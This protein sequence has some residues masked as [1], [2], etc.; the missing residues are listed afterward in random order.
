[1]RLVYQLM[2]YGGMGGAII[3][4]II[5]LIIF[6]RLKIWSIMKDLIGYRPR[7]KRN[8]P[9]TLKDTD[10]LQIRKRLTSGVI[11]KREIEKTSGL[12]STQLLQT[13]E[14]NMEETALLTEHAEV[15]ST[16]LLDESL[17]ETTIL[18]ELEETTL[19]EEKSDYF[20][21]N[22]EVIV[23]HSDEMI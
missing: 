18:T 10:K 16:T 14:R 20:V 2:F 1:M 9:A 3:T 11:S 22:E 17:E 8:L 23:V 4:F 15:A 6:F 7:K 12:A 21:K 5:A 19:L 13:S